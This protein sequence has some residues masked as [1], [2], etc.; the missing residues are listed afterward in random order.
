LAITKVR[1]FTILQPIPGLFISVRYAV[2]IC[3]LKIA[4]HQFFSL[5]AC[6]A[7]VGE[8][9]TVFSAMEKPDSDAR[10]LVSASEPLRRGVVH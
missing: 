1:I 5:L 10:K 7:I 3:H 8:K 6:T 9:P 4:I 2:Q